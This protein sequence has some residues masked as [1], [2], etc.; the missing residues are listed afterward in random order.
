MIVIS[1][2]MR[3]SPSAGEPPLCNP[4]IGWH[5]LVT[6]DNVTADTAETGFPASNMANPATARRTSWI[7]ADTTA[8]NLTVDLSYIGEIDYVALAGHNLGSAGI[9]LAINGHADDLDPWDDPL[10]SETMLPDNAPTIFRVS[11]RPQAGIQIPLGAGSEPARIAVLYV[12][13]LLTLDQTIR[14]NIP[15]VS[16][17]DAIMRDVLDGQSETGT[18]LGTVEVG[19]WIESSVQLFMRHSYYVQHVRAFLEARPPFFFAPFPVARPNDVGYLRIVNN[20]QATELFAPP[21]VQIGV[22]YRGIVK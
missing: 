18:Y 7:A 15:F 17:R 9:S 13:K 3:L 19:R 1:G 10:L 4:A 6:V 12:G 2:D 11:S 5:N 8:Q 22:D 16:P 20:P 21:Y 14:G